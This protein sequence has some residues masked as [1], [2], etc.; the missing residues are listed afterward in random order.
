VFVKVGICPVVSTLFSSVHCCI[1]MSN[2]MM[3]ID[4]KCQ[5]LT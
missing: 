2:A 4:V 1:V 3:F 5:F